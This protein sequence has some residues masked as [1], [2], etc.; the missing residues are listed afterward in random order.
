VAVAFTIG[1]AF[2]TVPTPLYSLYQR[3]DGFSTAV[4]TAIYACYAIG[5][6]ISLFLAGHVS[7]WL[8]RRRLLLCGLLVEVVSASVF[9]VWTSLAGLL[10]ARIICGIGVGL[11]TAT[12]TAYLAELH[13]V[14]RPGA[15]PTRA[16]LVATAANLGGLSL[17]PLVAGA[18]AQFVVDPL[19]VPYWVFIL[20]MV[21]AVIGLA[22]VP[23]TVMR[24]HRPYRRQRISV[25]TTSRRT[26]FHAAAV[27]FVAFALMG[28]FTGL[29]SSFV[30]GTIHDSSRLMAG[31]PAFLVFFCAAVAQ[32]ILGRREP[33]DLFTLGMPLLVGGLS[34]LAASVWIPSLELF[35]L[36]GAV[37]GAAA[38]LLFKGAMSTAAALAPPESRGEAAAG[39]FLAAYVGLTIPVVLVGI[40]ARFLSLPAAMTGF[41]A[42]VVLGC[43]VLWRGSSG[44]R[45]DSR[46]SLE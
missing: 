9:L 31:L 19:Q 36:G 21:L 4:I 12:A 38:G 11:I 16:D 46:S 43:A 44:A 27:A 37:S 6:L 34:V 2:T 45:P 1:M 14:A 32:L 26:Y 25:P 29:A 23:E 20:L 22:A 10:L 18:L 28:L 39:V 15:A 40:A 42:I 33:A 7:D 24:Q 8:G 35:L 5:V 3:R 30:A 13:S 17:G 41:A